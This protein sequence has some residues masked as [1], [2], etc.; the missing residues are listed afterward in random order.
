MRLTAAEK[1][2]L[3]EGDTITRKVRVRKETGRELGCSIQIGDA[4]KVQNRSLAV[5]SICKEREGPEI[6]PRKVRAGVRQN[7][8]RWV[9][10][11]EEVGEWAIPKPA[12]LPIARHELRK[13]TEDIRRGTKVL[14]WPAVD[15]EAQT[16]PCPVEKGQ[17]IPIPGVPVIE[18][19]SVNRK[20]PAGRKAEWHV[21]FI[22]HEVDRPQLLRRVPSGLA[23]SVRDHVGLSESEK[24]RIDGEYTSSLALS[25][26][27]EEPESV[28][29]DWE[30]PGVAEREMN[31]QKAVSSRMTEERILKEATNAAARV[32]QEIIERG[33]KGQDLTPLLA[34]IYE[35]LAVEGKE[36]A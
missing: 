3:A 9:I 26:G 34:D 19:E 14:V 2:L 21:T 8:A 28:G 31:R 33:A 32:K 7:P 5:C 25:L 36:A 23:S 6:P 1:E 17:R 30:D 13:I 24:A 11:F 20:L 16:V 22:R 35:R 12:P 18:I 29:P 15:E 10:R 4:V 27:K